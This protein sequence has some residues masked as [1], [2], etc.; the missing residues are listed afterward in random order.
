[1][2]F[3]SNLSC[4]RSEEFIRKN[5]SDQDVLNMKKIRRK[6]PIFKVTF[7][8]SKSCGK[9]SIIQ[10]NLLTIPLIHNTW[11]SNSE[12]Q[13]QYSSKLNNLKIATVKL[14]E[15][16]RFPGED[17]NSEVD[18]A[19]LDVDLYCL[20]F[21]T[22][23][24]FD[25]QQQINI[26]TIDQCPDFITIE[27]EIL[28]L[29]SHFSPQTPYV[30]MGCMTDLRNYRNR[31]TLTVSPKDGIDFA[32]KIG[33]ISYMES[34][35]VRGYDFDKILELLIKSIAFRNPDS[36]IDLESSSIGKCFIQ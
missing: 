26:P 5:V 33:A 4:F 28:P 3:S 25:D 31:N 17:N 7:I 24:N 2:K 12:Y 34:S 29:I 15:Y 19:L 22:F 16:S 21:S 32:K 14:C 36:D 11:D 9:S 35:T 8:G 20:C 1:M 6:L 10:K 18:N 30:V 23:H 27:K 13:F